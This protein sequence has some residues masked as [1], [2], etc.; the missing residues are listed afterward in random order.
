MHGRHRRTFQVPA[1][2][3]DMTV[4][5]NVMVGA[6]L[7]HHQPGRGRSRARSSK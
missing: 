4:L 2:F 1:T 3:E 7:R 5:E 6:F